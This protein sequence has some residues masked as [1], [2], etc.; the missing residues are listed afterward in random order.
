MSEPVRP[1]KLEAPLQNQKWVNA[2]GTATHYGQRWHHSVFM[3]L[4]AYEDSVWRSLGIGYTGL[5]QINMVSQR[6]SDLEAAT[7]AVAGAVAGLRGDPRLEKAVEA[8][9]LAI[10][11]LAQVQARASGETEKRLN[12]LTGLVASFGARMTK[13]QQNVQ[14]Q[15]DSLQVEASK[16][17]QLQTANLQRLGAQQLTLEDGFNALSGGLDQAARDAVEQYIEP[18]ASID[19]AG[20]G[21]MVIE[22]TN[23]TTLTFKLQGSDDV[24][25]SGTITLS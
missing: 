21:Q 16:S 22:A 23:D 17:A 1:V 12:D 13:A 25:R 19:P 10:T 7:A 14:M 15:V 5:T 3:R 11:A 24:V 2:D 8:L 4:G 9:Q 20:T 6:V 18:A